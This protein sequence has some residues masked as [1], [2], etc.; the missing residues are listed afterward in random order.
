MNL[1]VTGGSGFL[2][3]QLLARL[4]KTEHKVS[5]LARSSNSSKIV[6]DLGA[7]PI[8]GDLNDLQNWEV[9]LNGMD[10]VIH[11]AAPVE[12]WGPWKK[13]EQGIV[14]AT[15][16]LAQAAARQGVKRF[17]YIS[18]ESVLQDT[19]SLLDIDESQPFP[20][21]PNSYYGKAKML[22]EK[23]LMA[24]SLPIEIIILRPT[25][26]WGPES[27]AIESIHAKVVSG[28]FMWID[29]GRS[30]FEAVH[31]ENV[32]EAIL[33]ALSKGRNGGVYFVTDQEQSN[34]HQFFANL[35][36]ALDVPIP[37]K[38]LPGSIAKVAA[39][40]IE[41]VWRMVGLQMSPPLSRFELSFVMMPRRYSVVRAQS[42]L[43][44]RPVI[45]RK[46]GFESLK[47]KSM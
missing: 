4:G 31:V 42:E 18:S 8:N 3:K 5:A 19:K 21:E 29:Q 26:I 40:T 14:D 35:F 22:A 39:T 25:F 7:T 15:I 17:V 46:N 28:Q 43:E 33:C 32:V 23:K 44:Y 6:E 9:R 38:S 37:T 2:G 41:G 27:T 24:M 12:F 13:F 34:V 45:S 16:A 20:D 47:L 1:F 10:A 11:C 30:E 36:T